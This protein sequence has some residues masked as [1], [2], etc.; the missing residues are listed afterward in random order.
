MFSAILLWFDGNA[1]KAES[2]GRQ[3]FDKQHP[4]LKR[5]GCVSLKREGSNYVVAVFYAQGMTR[6]NP[7]KI[8]LVDVSI[9]VATE[10]DL[11]ACPEYRI[12][13]RK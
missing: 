10:V 2:V 7:Y 5:T 3:T 1:R 13:G 9:S 11:E 8:Y 12:R 4:T 6:P